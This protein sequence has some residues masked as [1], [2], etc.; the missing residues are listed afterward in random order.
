MDTGL[1]MRYT[2][3]PEIIAK[4]IPIRFIKGKIIIIQNYL[5]TVDILP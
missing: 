2:I 4:T 3:M 1:G 5:Y